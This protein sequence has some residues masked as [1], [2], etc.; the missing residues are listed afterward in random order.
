VTAAQEETARPSL[1]EIKTWPPTIRPR[2]AAP[3]LGLSARSVQV[4][5]AA[6]DFP[7][8]VIRVNGRAHIVTASLVAL[9]EAAQPE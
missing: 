5:I 6:G 9:L 2:Q 7:V 8:K 1:A 3:A 4:A